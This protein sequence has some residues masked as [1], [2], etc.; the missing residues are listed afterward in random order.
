MK[1]VLYLIL[2]LVFSVVTVQATSYSCRDK[3]GRLYITDNLQALPEECR[4]R[5]QMIKPE[6]PDN[7][8]F[9]PSP[10]EPQ[11][12]GTEFQQ[13]I[14]EAEHELQQKQLQV[15]RFLLR[16]EQLANQYQQA[17]QEKRNATRRWSYASRGIIQKADE[18]MRK[19]CEGKQQLL[20]EMNGQK[21]PRNDKQKI[22][23]LLEKIKDQ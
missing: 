9:V 12:S 13:K 7:L 22:N 20:K 23:F 6:T 17:E 15:E 21:I 1:K 2:I 14:R 4:G 11:G 16:A 8:N 3:E 10:A 19:A 18:R 5:T